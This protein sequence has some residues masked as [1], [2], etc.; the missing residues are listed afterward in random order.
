MRSSTAADFDHARE[1]LE[2]VVQRFAAGDGG[3]GIGDR[4]AAFLHQGAGDLLV[5]TSA[6]TCSA[7]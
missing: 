5:E 1:L 7:T 2:P 4:H 3:I 6:A